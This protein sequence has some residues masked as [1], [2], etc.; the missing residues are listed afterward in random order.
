MKKTLCSILS[1]LMLVACTTV[2]ALASTPATSDE[3]YQGL[4][5]NIGV[6]IGTLAEDEGFLTQDTA[7][8]A[9]GLP[10]SMTANGVTGL[11]TTYSSSGKNFTGGAFDAFKG[12]GLLIAGTVTHT[13]GYNVKVGACY[14]NSSND[15]FYSVSPQYFDSGVNNTGWIPK[16]AGSSMNFNNSMTYYGHITNHNGSGKVSGTLDFSVSTNPF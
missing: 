7:T 13:N 14:Y 12:T 15:T 10:F 4:V 16:M 9:T 1:V 6:P 8:K 5:T 2:S 3:L 11:L